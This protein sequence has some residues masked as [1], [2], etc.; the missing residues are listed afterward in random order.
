[1]AEFRIS[2][3]IAR[4]SDANIQYIVTKN[5]NEVYDRIIHNYI[6]GQ[7]SFSIIGSYGTGKSTFLWAFE[8]HLTGN[9]KFAKP[10]NAELKGNKN[11]QFLRIVGETNSFKQRFCES[12][13]LSKYAEVFI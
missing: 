12:F 2:T 3:N 4:D 13:G 6:R 9:L 1:M 11:F 7:H 10:I 5:S 8:K